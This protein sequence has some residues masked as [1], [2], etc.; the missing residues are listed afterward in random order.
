MI[1]KLISV[2]LILTIAMVM[3]ALVD[4][5]K[6]DAVAYNDVTFDADT[7]A[8]IY[9][10]GT[11]NASDLVV[12]SGS[13]AATFAT[14]LDKVTVTLLT[15]SSITFESALGK[16]MSVDCADGSTYSAGATSQM[17]VAYHASCPTVVLTIG[18]DTLTEG[19]VAASDLTAA[20]ASAY[21]VTFRTVNA[22]TTGQKIKL[23]FGTGFTIA[24]NSTA[25]NVTTLTDG[26][27]SIKS[28]IS[29]SSASAGK[30]ITVTLASDVAASSVINMVLNSALVTNPAITT[31]AVA[32][33]G[34]DIYTTT[35][36]GTT[37]D[38]LA[39]Q[40]AFNRVI[41]LE[42]GW[43]VFATSQALENTAYLTVLAPIGTSNYS[44][45]LTLVWDSTNSEMAW[46]TPATI[47]PLYGYAIYITASSTVKLPLDFAKETTSNITAERI[48]AHKGWYLI[49]YMGSDADGYMVAQ[50][51]C[52]DGMTVNGQTQFSFIVDLTGTG[53][54]GGT[55][56]NHSIGSSSKSEAASNTGMD[57]YQDFGYAIF[58]TS[59]NSLT[60]G[61][62]RERDDGTTNP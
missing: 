24:E 23:A 56:S 25:S 32:T 11:T 6:I 45:I 47:T 43:N 46:D 58:T 39:D 13:T 60:L 59:D 5:E 8:P 28:G 9:L 29:L 52:L 21:T 33:S 48:L 42:P 62:E 10:S 61:G 49:G 12:K 36:G 16:I 37:I 26:G 53:L 41:D 22:L 44:D 35:S 2:S 20:T 57:F 50:S 55:P 18:A 54:S 31:A 38:S 30:T 51:H 15:N 7:P 3:G 17:V 4:I 14:D 34:I 1:K 19:N 27:V 40:T